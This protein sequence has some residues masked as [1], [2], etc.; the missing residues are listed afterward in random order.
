MIR[1]LG[2]HTYQVQYRFHLIRFVPIKVTRIAIGLIRK[3]NVTVFRL[4]APGLRDLLQKKRLITLSKLCCTVC[5][6]GSAKVAMANYIVGCFAV[7]NCTN[8]GI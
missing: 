1:N 5:N 3:R 8:L 4:V 2:I 7:Y 6:H